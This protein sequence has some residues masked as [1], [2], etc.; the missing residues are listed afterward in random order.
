VPGIWSAAPLPNGNILVVSNQRFVREVDR[1][2]KTVWE[3]TPADAP[4]YKFTN[5]QLAVRLPNGNTIINDWF[6]QWNG[7]VNAT[8]A[9]VQA[10]EVTADKKIVWALHSW[11]PPAD[12]G[13]ATTIQLLDGN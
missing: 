1:S 5:L 13:P 9:P 2:G 12:L 7:Q 11:T 10:I 3:W 4:D 8:N 6:N